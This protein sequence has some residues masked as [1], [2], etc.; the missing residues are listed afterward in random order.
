MALLVLWACLGGPAGHFIS[1]GGLYQRVFSGIGD[2][3]IWIGLETKTKPPALRNSPAGSN[4]PWRF[5][6][7]ATIKK[8]LSEGDIVNTASL[9]K[10]LTHAMLSY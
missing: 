6:T 7:L 2:M 5:R 1:S 10:L 9:P 8:I 4:C 3:Q